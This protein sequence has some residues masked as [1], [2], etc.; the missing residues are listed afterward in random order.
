[1]EWLP[2][3]LQNHQ[4]PQFTE[5]RETAQAAAKITEIWQPLIRKRQQLFIPQSGSDSHHTF[6][7]LGDVNGNPNAHMRTPYMARRIHIH[8]HKS[9]QEVPNKNS[10]ISGHLAKRQSVHMNMEISPVKIHFLGILIQV[11][12]AKDEQIFSQKTM[13]TPPI[14]G[15]DPQY[16]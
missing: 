14:P 4:K 11:D 7:L 3:G 9:A 2:R 8:F 10:H 1:M 6:Q 5:H 16:D 15:S 12:G 13:G